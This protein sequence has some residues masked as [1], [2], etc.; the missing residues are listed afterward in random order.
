MWFLIPE[1]VVVKDFFPHD[2]NLATAECLCSD[3]LKYASLI[4]VK[5]AFN[6]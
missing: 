1:Q 4:Y 6:L 2:V 5:T 3:D